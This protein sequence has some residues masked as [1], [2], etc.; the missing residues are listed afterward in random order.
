MSS[1]CDFDG[2]C[3]QHLVA[4]VGGNYVI[5]FTKARCECLLPLPHGPPNPCQILPKMVPNRRGGTPWR[6]LSAPK[7]PKGTQERPKRPPET[8]KK[9]L[10]SPLGALWRRFGRAVG[11][12]W[13]PNG[14]QNGAKIVPKALQS[15]VGQGLSCSL[16]FSCDFF[17]DF[18]RKCCR[19]S[20]ISR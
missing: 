1:Y 19:F 15:G 12:F 17:K 14:D 7:R 13:E 16:R 9:R 18:Q 11:R 4:F 6:A 20:K 8:A 3:A 10:E 2:M 5:F